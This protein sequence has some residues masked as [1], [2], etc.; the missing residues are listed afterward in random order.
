M[1][2]ETMDAHLDYATYLI[3]SLNLST[4]LMVIG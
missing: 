3:S 2:R 4:T 1:Q